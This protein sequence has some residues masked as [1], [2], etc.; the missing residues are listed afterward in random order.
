MA[1]AGISSEGKVTICATIACIGKTDI[2]ILSIEF[3]NCPRP[4][5]AAPNKNGGLRHSFEHGRDET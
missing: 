3:A 1:F 2:S 5:H 4:R